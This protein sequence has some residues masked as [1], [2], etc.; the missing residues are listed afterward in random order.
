M[1]ESNQIDAMDG[2]FCI[3]PF[4]FKLVDAVV[5]VFIDGEGFPF[6]LQIADICG[7]HEY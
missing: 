6:A 4:L 5:V 2:V 1:N 3:F 7:A